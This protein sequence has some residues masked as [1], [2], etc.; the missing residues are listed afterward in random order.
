MGFILPSGRNRRIAGF[1]RA[2]V[3]CVFVL[4]FPSISAVG[5]TR[6]PNLT[7]NWV[8]SFDIIHPDGSVDPG[9]AY[10]L[11]AQ[12]GEKVTGSAGR[13]AKDQSPITSGKVVG[14]AV[15]LQVAVNAQTTVTFDLSIEN[16]R[17]KGAATGIPTE[18]GSRAVV[19]V[20][21][22]GESWQ[23]AAPTVHVRDRLFDTVAGLDRKLFD[24]YNTCDLDTL[25]ALVTDDLEF[26]H[27][28]TGL[29]VG[30]K[31]FLA[32]IRNNIC[33]KVQRVL[34]ADSL[35]VYRLNGYGA[36]EIGRHRFHHPGREQEGV[37]EAKFVMVWR[38]NNGEWKITRVLSYDHAAARD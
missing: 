26:Y 6:P 22:A 10:L 32:A 15:S 18:A 11:L 27:D 29:E 13:S 9:D 14:N 35:E 37:G 30:K 20:Q 23:T 8:G 12:N 25:G 38:L 4:L 34:I 17:L 1:S 5:Q 28:K 33:G 7:G 19:E 21:R 31:P 2:L 24:A 36:V 3:S 16:G